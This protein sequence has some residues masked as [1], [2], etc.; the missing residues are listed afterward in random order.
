[1]DRIVHGM[2]TLTCALHESPKI[3]CGNQLAVIQALQQAM[4]KW[5]KITLTTRTKPHMTTPPPTITRQRSILRPMCRPHEDPPQDVPPRL[6]I[7][8][9][10]A[11]PIPTTVPSTISHYEPVAR[12]TRS[13]V[14]Q[15]VDQPPPRVIQTPDTGPIS[16][17]TQSQTAALASVI[18]PA[19]AYQQQYPPQFLQ[20]MSMPVINET[21]RKS[22][23][24]RQLRNHPKFAHIWNTSY[25]NEL[26]L[27]CQVIGQG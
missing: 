23:L 7:Q 18:T 12:L 22:L 26:G 4:N 9:P 5:A 6:V 16:R 14:P 8:K 25:A 20:I 27:L 10:N 13:R 1:M 15:T 2:T 17:R 21:S 11:S 3:A 24:K 19:Q